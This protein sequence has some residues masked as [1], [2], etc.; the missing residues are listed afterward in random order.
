[1]RDQGGRIIAV[2]VRED[3]DNGKK[4]VRWERPDGSPGLDRPLL[5]LPLYGV[6]QLPIDPAIPVVVTE[7]EKAADALLINGIPAVGTVTGAY[8]TPGDDSLRPLSG[9]PVYLWPDNDEVG[10]KH[11][12]RIGAALLR[13]GHAGVRVITWPGAPPKGD[14]ADLVELEAWRDE[15]DVM[16]D[17]ARKIIITPAVE[18]QDPTG[19][20]YLPQ[21]PTPPADA[22]YHGIAGEFIRLVEPHTEGDPAAILA[23]FLVLFGNMIGRGPYVAIGADRHYTN[24]NAVVV[25]NTSKGRKGVGS[26]EAKRPLAQVDPVWSMSRSKGG[27]SSGEGLIWEVRDAIDK[28]EPIKKGGRIEGYQRVVVDE[29]QPDKRLM[30]LES[31]MASVLRVLSREGNTLSSQVRQAW[32]SGNLRC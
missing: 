14:A 17:S 29:G 12:E 24:I 4:K 13:L 1:L 18:T 27:M 16:V 26:G 28:Q 6:D 19:A 15:F 23:Q 30:V 9:R 8:G 22:A 32:D 11:M 10:K 5:A 2:H 25:G 21:F 31:E 20:T 7:G 3:H